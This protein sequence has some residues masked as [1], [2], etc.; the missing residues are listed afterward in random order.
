[1]LILKAL[2]NQ[3][4]EGFLLM[5]CGFDDEVFTI[6]WSFQDITNYQPMDDV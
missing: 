5:P 3:A 4:G 1:M 6:D 2:I